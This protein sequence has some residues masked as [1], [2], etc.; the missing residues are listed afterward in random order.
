MSTPPITHRPVQRFAVG[1][2]YIPIGKAGNLCTVTDFLVTYNLAGD[3]VQTRYVSTHQFCGQTVTNRDVVETT[4]AR[5]L[6]S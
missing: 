5:G 1:T 6:V 3:V 2:L 4:I